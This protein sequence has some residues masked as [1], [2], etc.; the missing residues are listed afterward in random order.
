MW[1]TCSENMSTGEHIKIVTMIHPATPDIYAV[2]NI[3]ARMH[4]P[5]PHARMHDA[6]M[7]SPLHARMHDARMRSLL[8]A[9]M[10][11][12]R[13]RSP[14]H[15][16]MHTSQYIQNTHTGTLTVFLPMQIDHHGNQPHSCFIK[17]SVWSFIAHMKQ[18]ILLYLQGIHHTIQFTYSFPQTYTE[19]CLMEHF[20]REKCWLLKLQLQ[21]HLFLKHDFKA[22][23]ISF[24]YT[25]QFSN[26]S[27][28]QCI[29]ASITLS[30]FH[31]HFLSH[32]LPL[33]C[34]TSHQAQR[35]FMSKEKAGREKKQGHCQ[36]QKYEIKKSVG[37]GRPAVISGKDLVSM[38][39]EVKNN[40]LLGSSTYRF[41]Q[42]TSSYDHQIHNKVVCLIPLQKLLPRLSLAQT[43]NIADRHNI[44]LPGKM[45]KRQI[46]GLFESHHC[47][48]CD[49]HFSVFEPVRGSAEKQKVYRKNI[50]DEVKCAAAAK[51]KA[52]KENKGSKKSPASR[53]SIRFPPPPLTT[54]LAHDIITGFCKDILPKEFIEAG[55]AVC[56]RL[57]KLKNLTKLKDFTGDLSILN[58]IGMTKA[59]RKNSTDPV[60][61]LTGN[62]L[63][64]DCEHICHSCSK[65]ILENK[66]PRHSLANGLWI[67]KVPPQLQNLTY[68]ESLL[69]ARVR[70]NRCV[71]Q[72]SSGGS[73]LHSNAITFANP[74]PKI[75]QRLPP[76]VEELDEVLAFIFTGP[77]QPTQ[78]EF[79]RTP[80]LVRRKKVTAALEWLKLNHIDYY[81]IDIAYD[82]IEQ[83]PEDGPPVV[84]DYRRS[85]SNK[86]PEATSV[87]DME[88]EMGT[89]QGDCPFVVHGITG[90]QLINK[91]LPM[92][93]AIAVSHLNRQGKV[94]AIGHEEKPESIYDNPKLYP[95]MFPWLFPY[96]L[97]GFGNVFN[98]HPISELQ[99]KRHLLMYH[100]KRFQMDSHFILIAFN[101]MQIKESTTGGY[102]LTDKQS[103]GEISD[104][105]MNLD[106]DV[107]EDL[108][109]RMATGE[110]VKPMTQEEKDCFQV[111]KDLDHVAGKVQGSLTS[112]KYMRNEI[113]SLI[114]YLG[115]PSWYITISPADVKHP[116]CLY[117]AD[118]N[119]KFEPTT[120]FD[121]E[122]ADK[123]RVLIAKNQEAGARFFD[124]MIRMFIKHVL[125][126]DSDH[127]GLYGDASAYYGTV[128]QQGRL[129]LHLHLL[130]WIRGAFTPQ[131]IRDKIMDPNSDF[132]R[133]LVEYL[134]SVHAG[135]F[136]EGTKEEVKI[137]RQTAELDPNYKPPTHTLPEAPPPLCLKPECK[138][139]CFRCTCLSIW[140]HKYKYVLDDLLSRSNVHTCSTAVESLDEKKAK[141]QRVGCINKYGNC[142][143]RFPRPTYDTTQVDP[144]TG[145]LNIKKGEAWINTFTPVLTYLF[146]CN[147]DVT[148]LLSGTAIKA[149]VA[150]ISDYIT[151]PSLKSHVIFSTIKSV[152]DN[153]SELLGGSLGRREKSRKMITKI[154]NSLTSQLEIGAPMAALYLLGNP[155]HYTNH[156]FVPCY[157]KSYVREA[158]SVW[159]QTTE[160]DKPERVVLTKK[161]GRLLGLSSVNDYVYRPE[162]YEDVC[163]YDWFRLSR[164][165]T[166]DPR[167]RKKKSKEEWSDEEIDGD[168]ELNLFEAADDLIAEEADEE[169]TSESGLEETNSES[170]ADDG[171]EQTDREGEDPVQGDHV[172]ED[173]HQVEHDSN[174]IQHDHHDETSIENDELNIADNESP[175]EPVK[176]KHDTKYFDF[177]EE[178]PLHETHHVY[179]ADEKHAK[180]PNFLG[181]SLP[182]RYSGD[183]EYY[184]SAMLAL[185]VPWRTGKD[186][187]TEQ[188]SWDESFTAHKFTKR[189]NEIMKFF[190]IK[191]ECLDARDDYSAEM[192][193]NNED[194]KFSQ[195]VSNSHND[196]IDDNYGDNFSTNI[197]PETDEDVTALTLP[198]KNGLRRSAKMKEMEEMLINAGWMDS[199]PNGKP[200]VGDLQPV[201]PTEFKSGQKWKAQVQKTRQEVIDQRRQHMPNPAKK[202]SKFHK[203]PLAGDVKVVDKAYLNKVF[204]AVNKETQEVIDDTAEEFKL[205]EEQERA[206]RIVANHVA[207]SDSEQLKMYLAGMGGTGKSQV[208]KALITLF[209][210]IKQS[211]RFLVM[212][213][214][215]SAAAL[216]GGSTYHSVLGI[217]NKDDDYG[218][219]T[220]QARVKS[221]LE[222]VEYI[223]LDEVSMLSCLDMYRICSQMAKS[224]GNKEDTF[225]GINM[226]FAGDFAQLPPVIGGE[227]ASL[228]SGSIGTQL[229][230]GLNLNGQKSAIGKA[231]WHQVTVVVILRQNMRQTTQ[232]P[233]DAMLRTAL[234]NMRFKACTAED[235]AFLRTRISSINSSHISDKRFRNVSIITAQNASKDKMNE[236][237]SRRFAKENNQ[238]LTDFYSVDQLVQYEPSPDKSKR[239]RRIKKSVSLDSGKQE[240]LWELTP[241]ATEHSPGKLSLCIG[242]PVMI[243]KNEATELCITKGQEGTVAGWQEGE[244]PNGQRILETLFVRLTN[245]PQT[246]QIEGLPENVIPLVKTKKTIT[247]QFP[248]DDKILIER[249]QVDVLPN[250]SMTDYA[251]QGK[252]RAVNVVYL[253][254]CRSHQ[255]YYT[256]LSRSASAADTMI[257]QGF[258]TNHITGGAS[259]WLRQEFRELEL[260]DTITKLKYE[261]K[262]PEHVEGV[263]RN[264]LLR[265]FQKWKGADYM[266]D[267]TH[268]ALR[269]DPQHPTKMINVTT[270]STW[271]ILDKRVKT[272]F[273][274]PTTF[275]AA[276]GSIP[277]NKLKRERDEEDQ[278]H[279]SK[280]AKKHRNM[281]PEAADINPVI[282]IPIKSL[283]GLI[284]DGPNYSCAY[285]A[286]MTTLYHIWNVNPKKWTKIFDAFNKDY[287]GM[288]SHG[289]KNMQLGVS[290]LENIRDNVRA[291]LHNNKPNKYPY[292]QIGTDISEL[293]EDIVECEN[294]VSF[295]QLICTEC[296]Y[297]GPET[298]GDIKYFYFCGS[299]ATS[300]SNWMNTVCWKKTAQK[301]PECGFDMIRC[302]KYYEAPNLLV[303]NVHGQDIKVNKKI[304][305]MHKDKAKTFRLRGMTYFGGFHHISR[306]IDEH[307]DIWY[308]DGITTG[309]KCIAENKKLKDMTYQELLTCKNKK[310]GLAI[311][312]R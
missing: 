233:E 228:Y 58:V 177:L 294:V 267:H 121:K 232:T 209:K 13:M 296:D 59:E 99:H 40:L 23:R 155:D 198:G 183:R 36:D 242:L 109:K 93:K 41:V 208:I 170:E 104:R 213:P 307:G 38:A 128:E 298:E 146:R 270:D 286:F 181:G 148:S 30:H 100:D 21:R 2:R 282:S 50:S 207:S 3:Y 51:R 259:G 243:R 34:A 279:D 184:C 258:A 91:T 67:G 281:K 120:I 105:L 168:D 72:V 199:S 210:N 268:P 223:F 137:R 145:A 231:V 247:C 110:H 83:Y 48:K 125:G 251:S 216:L 288:L 176:Q 204:C 98:K 65:D 26:K 158:R 220:D 63:D 310:I 299:A 185:F 88:D 275:V 250:F 265:A 238:Q 211:H 190:N 111:I 12:A 69:I 290:P 138:R 35:A 311:Y 106:Q 178:H 14:L 305:L 42:H 101:H 154:V 149:V 272:D 18:T 28:T 64:T 200:D 202:S 163:L 140:W 244:G 112:K 255:A 261:N 246:I 225:G 291:K 131:E 205:N 248:N 214:T 189:Q 84:V 66:L 236:L 96:G 82:N 57:D 297:E 124:F 262:L 127:P 52:R 266:P 142:K 283:A 119:V 97:G 295:I 103:F 306:V 55:C 234:E 187:K 19:V 180:I 303:F 11:D 44:T 102:L 45:L 73:K 237:G 165:A 122:A 169:A 302:Q 227:A 136:F 193:K 241:E 252:T 293:A 195:W 78:E 289:F 226:I 166:Q 114:S 182:R 235:I 113:W 79:K 7:R 174:E 77:A 133:K 284:W 74:T 24:K 25:F 94:M 230:S 217:R 256:A 194:N 269:C 260:L 309:N 61:D 33:P 253:N 287:L 312:A 70:H 301:C 162:E 87:H 31:L 108:S 56:G 263:T 215:G 277:V 175:V 132:Q 43:R 249:D 152:F 157:W 17:P 164:K 129:T 245:P 123:A 188:Q 229:H 156:Q 292:G 118:T 197:Q 116:I 16:K 5:I 191:Y 144:T 86:V 179:F 49:N 160:E 53:S 308:H 39:T 54:R 85:D 115:A 206:F 126:V 203:D 27:C 117:Y 135:E 222:G 4:T 240:I 22:Y 139:F 75:Y 147:T 221:N 10:H 9:R 90:E 274:E 254:N 151:K 271:Q 130:L 276:A 62:I 304:V 161:G 8:H 219:A 143:A 159:H 68:T 37:G 71:K 15:A 173:Q 20:V 167:H 239:K 280:P 257:V 186:L 76:P 95:Q 47:K 212:A 172:H 171:V 224:T 1:M 89:E 153:S 107:L 81:D 150:Y 141:K 192:K 92:L 29:V 80:L 218:S 134:E 273:K 201:Q 6:R 32:I 278:D 285:D 264:T 60:K 46:E 300:T 196:D